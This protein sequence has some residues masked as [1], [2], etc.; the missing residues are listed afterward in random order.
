M[1]EIREKPMAVRGS[2]VW[3]EANGCGGSPIRS[4]T[5]LRMVISGFS[6]LQITSADRSTG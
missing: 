4:C 5:P 1:E 3:C 2:M 6:P